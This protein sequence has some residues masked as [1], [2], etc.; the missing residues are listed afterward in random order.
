MNMPLNPDVTAY[1]QQLNMPSCV[2]KTG[3]FVYVQM[4]S[5]KMVCQVDTMWENKE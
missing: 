3:D 2:I 4:E 1:Y 5:G